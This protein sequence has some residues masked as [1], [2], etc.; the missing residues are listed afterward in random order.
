MTW[1]RSVLCGYQSVI[2]EYS[3]PECYVIVVDM[4]VLNEQA[5]H[6]DILAQEDAGTISHTHLPLPI[7]RV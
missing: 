5:G 3:F 7:Q 2:A 6:L 4:A 1:V